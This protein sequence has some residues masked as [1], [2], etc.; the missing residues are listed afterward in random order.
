MS[1]RTSRLLAAY[2]AATSW[3]RL[4]PET[5][6]EVKRRFLDSIGVA[7]AGLDE[8]AAVAARAYAAV[9]P[10]PNGVTVW[11]S[12]LRAG[13]EAAAFANGVAVRCLDFNDTYLSMEPLHPSD[14]IPALIAL[15]E[16]RDASARELI[17]AIAVAYEVSVTLCDAA[18]LRTRG[19]DHVNFLGIGVACSAGRLLGLSP[20]RI[21]HAISIATVPHAAMRQT[22]SGELSMWK[23]TAAANSARNAIFA[24]LLA[25]KGMTGPSEPFE[26]EMG[27][28][29]QLLGGEGFDED[30][31]WRLEDR[32][33][34]TRILDTFI[35][36]WPVEYHA[37]SAVEAA[38]QLPA[39]VLR[40]PDRIAAI[41]IETLKPSYDILAKDPE[42]WDPNTRETADHSLPYIATAALLDGEVTRRTFDPVRFREPRTLDIVKNRVTV[43]VLHPEFEEGYPEGVLNR[44]SVTTGDGRIFVA[45]V[46]YPRGHARNP[47]SDEEVVTKYRTNVAERWTPETIALV[48]HLVWD[49]E[50]QPG[51]AELTAALAVEP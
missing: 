26:G 37:Q 11:G 5:V 23:G 33:P 10:D 25:S 20:S 50:A 30:V 49:L 38:L 16:W 7:I 46:A 39:R 22:R 13:P 3:D 18:S 43:E 14:A 8:R 21:E 19:W 28:I 35:K 36:F 48:Q 29:E 4:P 45:E 17:A 42:K 2:A 51:I 34:P 9:L 6:H 44:I 12:S 15:A 31:L 47:M 24:A 32:A 41:R 40:D 1:D 27:L